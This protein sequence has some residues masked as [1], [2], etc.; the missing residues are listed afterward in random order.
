MLSNSQMN[1]RRPCQD[2]VDAVSQED[3]SFT[4]SN[5]E[6]SSQKLN[7]SRHLHT[8]HLKADMLSALKFKPDF[9]R[10]SA[11]DRWYQFGFQ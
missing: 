11:N 10:T 6:Q 9:R 4:P 8:C 7:I 5:Q 1:H 3:L 2:V